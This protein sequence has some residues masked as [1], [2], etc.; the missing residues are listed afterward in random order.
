MM[1]S[2]ISTSSG[3]KCRCCSTPFGKDDA[4]CSQCG[5]K[6]TAKCDCISSSKC[7]VCQPSILDKT[8]RRSADKHRH[9]IPKSPMVAPPAFAGS[10]SDGLGMTAAAVAVATSCNYRLGFYCPPEHLRTFLYP[11]EAAPTTSPIPLHFN[12]CG[13]DKCLTGW[14]PGNESNRC[15]DCGISF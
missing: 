14:Q 3:Y 2:S 12:Y 8:R 1:T 13:N 4:Y 11:V 5:V 15:R 6:R 7:G 10:M 9:K